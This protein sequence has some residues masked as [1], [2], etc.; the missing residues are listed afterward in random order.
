VASQFGNPSHGGVLPHYELVM[1]KPMRRDEFFGVFGPQDAA[2]LAVGVNHVETR[3]GGSVPESNLKKGSKE[4][5]CAW[6][7]P[8]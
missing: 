2:H 3:A 4:F 7:F 5:E 6:K 1:R 8:N